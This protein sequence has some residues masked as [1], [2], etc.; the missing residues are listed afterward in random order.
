M[1]NIIDMRYYEVLSP[2][3]SVERRYNL[4]KC[5]IMSVATFYIF[6]MRYGIHQSILLEVRPNPCRFCSRE[7][8]ITQLKVPAEGAKSTISNCPYHYKGMQYGKSNI[9]SKL[10]PNTNV[11]IHCSLC[12]K[13]ISSNGQTIW[14]YNAL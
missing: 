13:A 5:A 14:K 10:S 11:P 3:L 12:F 2:V 9:Y 8:C 4:I 7:E 6:C 1:S